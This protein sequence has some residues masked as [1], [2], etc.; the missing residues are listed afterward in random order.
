MQARENV[1]Q[2][3]PE[4]WSGLYHILCYNH[5][6]SAALIQFV[7]IWPKTWLGPVRTSVYVFPALICTWIF[8]LKV[9]LATV[10]NEKNPVNS[11]IM[12]R[13]FAAWQTCDLEKK[14]PETW[15]KKKRSKNVVKI[16]CVNCSSVHPP[17]LWDFK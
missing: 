5:A 2:L 4:T 10:G 8:Q 13:I 15:Q 16:L 3:G 7:W 14:L 9:N 1:F 6:K 12:S 17:S 11:N